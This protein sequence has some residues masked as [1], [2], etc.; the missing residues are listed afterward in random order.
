MTKN[1]SPI[2][3]LTIVSIGPIPLSNVLSLIFGLQLLAGKA[4]T[5]LLFFILNYST[6]LS[7]FVP[8]G[9]PHNFSDEI[10]TFLLVWISGFLWFPVIPPDYFPLLYITRFPFFC[11][12]TASEACRHLGSLLPVCRVH[13]VTMYITI[14]FSTSWFS[15]RGLFPGG[16]HQ[17]V[18]F[19]PV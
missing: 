12:S 1:S 14:G 19:H 10:S 8:S 13:Q 5:L 2:I 16:S 6:H 9:F 18:V 11:V 7:P 4:V 17:G 3:K 15:R